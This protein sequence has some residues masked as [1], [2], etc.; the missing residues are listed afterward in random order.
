MKT[1]TQYIK[2]GNQKIAIDRIAGALAGNVFYPNSEPTKGYFV[3]AVQMNAHHRRNRN[4]ADVRAMA[5]IN[6]L[7]SATMPTF[8]ASDWK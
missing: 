2:R 8:D 3:Y 1:G 6:V 5:A 4:A 7:A